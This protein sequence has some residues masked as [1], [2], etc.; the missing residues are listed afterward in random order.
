MLQAVP[1]RLPEP[2]ELPDA[3][4]DQFQGTTVHEMA[5]FLSSFLLNQDFADW[6]S[7]QTAD[8]T[9]VAQT[10]LKTGLPSMAELDGFARTAL[11]QSSSQL[12][13]GD[14][15]GQPAGFLYAIPLM[16]E[17][18]ARGALLLHRPP[19]AGPLNH[20][21]PAIVHALAG[22]LGSRL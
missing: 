20:D 9:P 2:F 15:D 5:G 18:G 6:V 8:L 13:M 1:F 22:F 12:I 7:I 10:P 19:Q 4:L 11:E 17:T 3:W 14:V 16:G 21:Q